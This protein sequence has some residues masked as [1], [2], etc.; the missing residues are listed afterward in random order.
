MNRWQVRLEGSRESITVAT[1]QAVVDGLRDGDWDTTDTVRG[2]GEQDWLPIED[3]PIFAEA[4]A[5]MGPPPSE[6]PDETRLDMNPL[7]DVALV[8]LIFFIL[9]TTYE[10]LRRSIDLPPEPPT[11]EGSQSVIVKAED[12]KDR[13]F[14]V[15]IR[16]NGEKPIIQLENKLITVESLEREVA[17]FVK[18]T[19]RKELFAEI[20]PEVPWGIEAQLY[21]AAK[22]AGIHQIYWPKGK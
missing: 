18:S 12:I 1:P 15:Q 10:S 19:G 16:M 9:T 8:L 17:E 6:P 4:V 7:I 3:H 11:R 20:A 13:S 2:P 5:E 22:G 14:K 21:D